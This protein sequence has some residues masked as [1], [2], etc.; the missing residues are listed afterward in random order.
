MYLMSVVMSLMNWLTMKMM[1]RLTLRTC[2]LISAT[3]MLTN[4]CHSFALMISRASCIAMMFTCL[5]LLSSR[6]AVSFLGYSIGTYTFMSSRNS[7]SF[8]PYISRRTCCNFSTPQL[9]PSPES[10]PTKQMTGL[11]SII[12]LTKSE[13]NIFRERSSDVSVFGSKRTMKS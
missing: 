7:S 13:Y 1:R 3:A 10:P 4:P 8:F 6:S 12:L 5:S 9:F 2:A 11:C